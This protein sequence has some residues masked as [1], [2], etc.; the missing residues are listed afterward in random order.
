MNKELL[1]QLLHKKYTSPGSHIAEVM[2]DSIFKK[3]S[4][5]D[6]TKFLAAYK[7]SFS[8]PVSKTLIKPIAKA[9]VAGAA[10]TYLLG[11]NAYTNYMNGLFEPAGAT[12]ELIKATRTSI[13]SRIAAKNGV[14]PAQYVDYMSE[15]APTTH[16]LMWVPSVMKEHMLPFLKSPQF[17]RAAALAGGATVAL[18][19]MASILKSTQLKRR[20]AGVLKGQTPEESLFEAHEA[21]P[22]LT[23]K[24]PLFKLQKHTFSNLSPLNY[25]A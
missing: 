6:Q 11:H 24:D 8:A 25:L 3:L 17:L 18:I 23:E 9:S 16:E 12:P 7:D 15:I 10:A 1:F 13:L 22:I 21:E 19:A 14:N 2:D 4:L 20:A 5:E